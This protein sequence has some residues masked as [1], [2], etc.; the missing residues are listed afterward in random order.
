MKVCEACGGW[1]NIDKG[2]RLPIDRVLA[3]RDHRGNEWVGMG[4]LTGPDGERATQW[5]VLR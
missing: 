4:T 3:F 1:R 2:D 5:G